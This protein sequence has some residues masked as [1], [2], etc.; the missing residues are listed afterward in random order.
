ML[1]LYDGHKVTN[2]SYIDTAMSIV[3]VDVDSPRSKIPTIALSVRLLNCL[4]RK[5]D[6]YVMP[7][8]LFRVRSKTPIHGTDISRPHPTDEA[9]K[10]VSC[11]RAHRTQRSGWPRIRYPEF[12]FLSPR[13][14]H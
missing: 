10:I 5:I 11:L 4:D 6:W 12:L 8:V 14:Y 2:K 9:M 3:S 1:F 7:L 13:L